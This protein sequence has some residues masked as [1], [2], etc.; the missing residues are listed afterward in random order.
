VLDASH[1]GGALTR[2]TP[3]ASRRMALEGATATRTVACRPKRSGQA[4]QGQPGEVPHVRE[5][6]GSMV[7]GCVGSDVLDVTSQQHCW[8]RRHGAARPAGTDALTS[9]KFIK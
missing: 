1:T 4:R 8:R 2:T 7:E 5:P 3:G 6:W 9:I